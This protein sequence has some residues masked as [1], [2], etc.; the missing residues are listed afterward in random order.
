MAR[1]KNKPVAPAA[2]SAVEAARSL[3]PALQRHL[4]IVH[5]PGWQ[6]LDDW[7]EIA[8]MVRRI[9]P[10]TGVVIVA[11]DRPDPELLKL[12]ASLPSLVFSAGPLGKFAPARG[13]VYH[14][15]PI[16][17]FEQL[18]RLAAG[19]VRVPMSTV[20]GPDT[21]LDPAMWGEFVVLKP[22]DI[23]T[24]SQGRGIQ[25]MRTVRVRYIKPENYPE[26]HP[27][28]RAPMVVQQF[29]NSGPRMPHYRVLTLFGEPL[30]CQM[31]EAGDNRV[32]LS[33]DDET[34]EAAP[35]ALNVLQGKTKT[36]L[37]RADVAALARAAYRAIPEAPLQGCDIIRDAAT[38]RL[39]V[40]ELNPG[41]NTWHFSSDFQA[42]LRA[43]DGP[44]HEARRRWH[45]DAFG[46]AA[47]VLADVTRREAV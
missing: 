23:A 3:Q 30:Y 31:S 5:Q 11:A 19:R 21:K 47:H 45:L 7:Y 24:S 9:D 6:A 18:R 37:Y 43:I 40:L 46:T 32:D 2:A 36:F 27:G 41:G 38:D 8:Q 35:V 34:I 13:K 16:H 22:T 17:K 14:G 10:T 44:E 4:V 33:S 25:L 28:R 20:L 39:Y 12:A 29:I 1:S 42:P 15:R 26:D